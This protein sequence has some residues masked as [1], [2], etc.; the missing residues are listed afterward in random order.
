[1]T[2]GSGVP[3]LR[4]SSSLSNSSIPSAE[5]Y[6]RRLAR[7]GAVSG[8]GGVLLGLLVLG[9]L[10]W[11][12]VSVA[13]GMGFGA[14][15][16]VAT[17]FG[18]GMCTSRAFHRKHAEELALQGELRVQQLERIRCARRALSKKPSRTQSTALI[19]G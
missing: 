13:L 7:D 14:A 4:S 10:V 3:A 16:G 9:A 12:G 6:V 8:V 5:W 11:G 1:M 19:G 2:N 18:V 15:I 17:G